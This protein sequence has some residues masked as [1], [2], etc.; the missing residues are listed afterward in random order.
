MLKQ[1]LFHIVK[2]SLLFLDGLEIRI[3]GTPA[4]ANERIICIFFCLINNRL[5]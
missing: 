1:K 5:P 4:V 2:V 3:P